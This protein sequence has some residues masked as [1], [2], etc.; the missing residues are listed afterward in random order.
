MGELFGRILRMLRNIKTPPFFP[1]FWVEVRANVKGYARD[2]I[3][4]NTVVLPRIVMGVGIGLM[5]LVLLIFLVQLFLYLRNRKQ[6]SAKTSKVD[7][8]PQNGKADDSWK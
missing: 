6:T 3:Y 8:L 5:A 2:Y 7:S 4:L 1:T